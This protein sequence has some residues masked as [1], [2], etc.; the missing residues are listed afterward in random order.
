MADG[1]EYHR[2]KKNEPEA[3]GFHFLHG[4]IAAKHKGILYACWAANHGEENTDTEVVCGCCSLDD[5][6]SWSQSRIWIRGEAHEGVSHGALLS[7]REG[8]FGFFPHFTGNREHVRMYLYQ[9][10]DGEQ[11]E[12]ICKI[13][14]EPFW[15]LGEPFRMENGNYIMPGI[16]VGGKW[17]SCGNPAAVAVSDGNDLSSWRIRIIPKPEDM[18]IWGESGVIVSGNRVTCIFRCWHSDPTALVSVSEDFGEHWSV[19]ERTNLAMADSKPCAGILS[20]GKPYLIGTTVADTGYL[21]YPLTIALGL[22]GSSIFREIKCIRSY[23]ST[24]D[25]SLDMN[26]KML[27]AYPYATEADGKLYITYSVGIV[28][29][30]VHNYNNYAEMAIVSVDK[31]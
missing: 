28:R 14:D 7:V 26:E 27:L 21:R 13:A 25:G 4:V 17:G 15:P 31:L 8:L 29:N 3:D 18:V 6:V 30:R 2:I 23:N 16:Y 11:W 24:M 20:S 5:G 1:V 9:L 19:T 10:A 22:P 12:K